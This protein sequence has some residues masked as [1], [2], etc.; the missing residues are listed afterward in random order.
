VDQAFRRS[1]AQIFTMGMSEKTP[2]VCATRP[3]RSVHIGCLDALTVATIPLLGTAHVELVV[4]V[5]I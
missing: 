2:L 5:P 3:K 1:G 4:L